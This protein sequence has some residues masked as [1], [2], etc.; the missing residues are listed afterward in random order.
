MTE[1]GITP[2]DYMKNWLLEPNFSILSIALEQ[3]PSDKAKSRVNLKQ[4]R[5]LLSKEASQKKLISI[6]L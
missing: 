2:E 4:K 1:S 6:C 3:N 5:F